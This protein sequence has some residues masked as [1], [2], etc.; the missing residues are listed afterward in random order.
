MTER[1]KGRKCI[2]VY[3]CVVPSN[4]P[5]NDIGLKGALLEQKPLQKINCFML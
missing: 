2:S 5:F 1:G 4:M 3:V